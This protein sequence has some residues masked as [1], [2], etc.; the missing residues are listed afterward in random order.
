MKYGFL[1]ATHSSCW[2]CCCESALLLV[3]AEVPLLQ[4]L[5]CPNKGWSWAK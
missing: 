4:L 1:H 5:L 2:C 3:E